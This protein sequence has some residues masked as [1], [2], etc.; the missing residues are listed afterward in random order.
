MQAVLATSEIYLIVCI[1][2]VRLYRTS[3]C[4]T[5]ELWQSERNSI[6]PTFFLYHMKDHSS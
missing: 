6:V 4:Q 3:V 2:N 5:R 1:E